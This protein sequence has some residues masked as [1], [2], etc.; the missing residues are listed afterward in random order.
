MKRDSDS[1]SLYTF[2]PVEGHVDKFSTCLVHAV[3]VGILELYRK[4]LSDYI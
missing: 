4:Q 3:E 1:D 2:L